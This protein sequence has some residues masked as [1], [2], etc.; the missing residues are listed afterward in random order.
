MLAQEKWLGCRHDASP[1]V[2]ILESTP[3]WAQYMYFWFLLRKLYVL[4]FKIYM[5]YKR[6]LVVPD[7]VLARRRSGN[8]FDRPWCFLKRNE[9]NPQ[10][11]CLLIL[12]N[13]NW[14]TYLL[15][16]YRLHDYMLLYT[17]LIDFSMLSLWLFLSITEHMVA[18]TLTVFLFTS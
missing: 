2:E 7:V 3:V 8:D 13:W 12:L 14:F 10:I 17:E 11:Y 1:M 15:Y 16:S 4:C 5:Y 6:I 18:H 9:K